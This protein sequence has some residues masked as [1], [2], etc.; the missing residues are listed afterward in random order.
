ML[1]RTFGS[2]ERVEAEIFVFERSAERSS[3]SPL[4]S[5]LR[6]RVATGDGDRLLVE[7]AS[8]LPSLEPGEVDASAF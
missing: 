2:G 7:G 5:R 8:V 3:L 6:R 4:L 1:D